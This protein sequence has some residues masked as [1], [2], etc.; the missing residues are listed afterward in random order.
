MRIV[1]KNGSCSRISHFTTFISKDNISIFVKVIFNLMSKRIFH[2]NIKTKINKKFIYT[3]IKHITNLDL[4]IYQK[5]FFLNFPL[6]WLVDLRRAFL[7][8]WCSFCCCLI[9]VNFGFFSTTYCI[10]RLPKECCFTDSIDMSSLSNLS[11]SEI[12]KKRKKINL[13][14]LI[15]IK[16]L[17]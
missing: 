1:L 5:S 9:L 8:R 15:K 17:I 3:N 7:S 2:K 11:E 4:K 10:S 6:I 12:L 13:R 14:P 16:T